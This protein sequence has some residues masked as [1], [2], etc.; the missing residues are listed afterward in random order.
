[1]IISSIN[2]RN[3]TSL[4]FYYRWKNNNSKVFDQRIH[5]C[6]CFF[7]KY[8]ARSLKIN[9]IVILTVCSIHTFCW[10]QVTCSRR[11]TVRDRKLVRFSWR[12]VLC[13]L[14]DGI[15][16]SR[17]AG[18]RNDRLVKPGKLLRYTRPKGE[19]TAKRCVCVCVGYVYVTWG[20]WTEK[21]VLFIYKVSE[22]CMTA[23]VQFL[24]L[25]WFFSDIKV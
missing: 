13:S 18:S 15:S 20:R 24:R 12:L 19:C 16:V 6:N 4:L 5:F 23:W 14:V 11:R 22:K 17:P 3:S 9:L 8:F 1:M 21:Y 10:K 2:N 7:F 25:M